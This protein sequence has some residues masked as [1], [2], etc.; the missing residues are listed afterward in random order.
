MSHKSLFPEVELSPL[1]SPLQEMELVILSRLK[2]DLSTVTPYDFL[3]H[4]L[5]LV[6]ENNGSLLETE[7]MKSIRNDAE[8]LIILC[9]T[10]FR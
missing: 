1:I 5:K 9:A 2:W 8:K 3:E 4:L 7:Q 6:M 10:E